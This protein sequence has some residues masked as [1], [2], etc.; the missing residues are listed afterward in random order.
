MR[1]TPQSISISVFSKSPSNKIKGTSI[2]PKY[3]ILS[4]LPIS[5]IENLHSQN[6]TYVCLK[7][8]AQ[9]IN[10]PTKIPRLLAS[11]KIP[12]TA[13]GTIPAPEKKI[14]AT[15]TTIQTTA[16]PTRNPT[17]IPITMKMTTKLPT[18]AKNNGG[19]D[20]KSAIPT[21]MI[22]T[23]TIPTWAKSMAMSTAKSAK[24]RRYR[25]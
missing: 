3:Q 23:V 10:Q 7:S 14:Q 18:P 15:S 16:V 17:A 8:Q 5:H 24:R 22:P 13:T 25:K 11:K 2:F 19:T 12:T 1:E 9:S 6:I 20:G 21:M 4:Q